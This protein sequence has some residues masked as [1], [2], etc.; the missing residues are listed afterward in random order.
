MFFTRYL[1][2]P[3]KNRGGVGPALPP[4]GKRRRE[5]IFPSAGT[6]ASISLLFIISSPGVRNLARLLP[7]RLGQRVIGPNALQILAVLT[8]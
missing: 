8:F 6:R 2:T 1:F 3:P 4:P 7:R 5:M